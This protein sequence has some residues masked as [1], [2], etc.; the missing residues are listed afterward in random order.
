MVEV[1]IRDF[2]LVPGREIERNSLWFLIYVHARLNSQYSQEKIIEI[3]IHLIAETPF[4]Y[5]RQIR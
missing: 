5:L 2:Q 3:L 1:E 4:I